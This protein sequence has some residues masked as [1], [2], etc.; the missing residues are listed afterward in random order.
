MADAVQA[1]VEQYKTSEEE[2]KQLK[3]A[4]VSRTTLSPSLSLS[5]YLSS[6][7]WV[8][9]VD[10]EAEDSGLLTDKTS[11]LGSAI[12]WVISSPS[13]SFSPPPDDVCS[14]CRSLPELMEKKKSIDMHTNIATALL[15]QIK[16][17]HHFSSSR[18]PPLS[19]YLSLPKGK[20]VRCVF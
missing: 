17:N 8:Q 19:L 1:E 7:V 16:V 4:M 10:E 3:S 9:G 20:K 15:E 18:L 11:K 2:M 6:L 5:L 12:K 13:P 14:H